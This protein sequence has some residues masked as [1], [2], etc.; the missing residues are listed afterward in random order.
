MKAVFFLGICLLSI[1]LQA[2]ELRATDFFF[3]TYKKATNMEARTIRIHQ[4]PEENKCAVVYSVNGKDNMLSYGRW[5]AF[6]KNKAEQVA[7][8][9][10]KSLWQCT[11]QE[12][13]VTVV[14][15]FSKKP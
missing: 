15:S 2:F 12:K 5:L 4:F 14:Y 1:P 8:N 11:K 7:E 13:T 3:C 10:Q 9:L 6:C